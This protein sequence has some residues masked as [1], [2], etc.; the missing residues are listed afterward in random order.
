MANMV[1]FNAYPDSMCGKL[2]DIVELLGRAEMKDAFSA[3]YILPS[4]FISDLDRGFSIVSYDLNDEL[5]SRKDL[6]QLKELGIDLKLD[7]VLNHLSIQSKQFQD[8]LARGQESEYSDFFIN[9][10]KFWDGHGTMTAGGYIQPDAELIKNMFFRKPGLPI[11]MVPM[12]DGSKVPYW[13]T[14]Y[15]EVVEEGKKYLGFTRWPIMEPKLSGWTHSPMHPK[16]W[17]RRIS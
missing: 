17:E 3:F 9:W 11:L 7:F 4:V 5:A 15:Q 13:N 2:K 8:I 14:F 1:I 10:N 12:P 16:K 6:E